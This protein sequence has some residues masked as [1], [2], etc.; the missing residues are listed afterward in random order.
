M[1]LAGL[2]MA[3]HSLGDALESDRYQETLIR[4]QP[5]NSG[6]NAQVAAWRGQQ[7]R[8]FEL[9]DLWVASPNLRV[10]LQTNYL[11]P[12]F[13]TLHESPGWDQFL[14]AI[15]RA[16]EQ[17]GAIQFNVLPFLDEEDLQ[18]L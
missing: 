5:G 2:A 1:R 4:E 7:D 9:L 15:G 10:R 8:A 3:S 18:T 12:A 11:N 6:M 17:I 13:K 14:A 16:P